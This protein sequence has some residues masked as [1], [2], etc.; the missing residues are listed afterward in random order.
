MMYGQKTSNL[1]HVE[2]FG[3]LQTTVLYEQSLHY[4]E[5]PTYIPEGVG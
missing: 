4:Q 3:E 5:M 1:F 2:R